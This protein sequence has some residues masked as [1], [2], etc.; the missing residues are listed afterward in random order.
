MNEYVPSEKTSNLNSDLSIPPS[1]NVPVRDVTKLSGTGMNSLSEEKTSH[2]EGMLELA[3][4]YRKIAGCPTDT[5]SGE[6]ETIDCS[7]STS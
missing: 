6:I 5:E 3:I 1:K 7:T 2:S 4:A